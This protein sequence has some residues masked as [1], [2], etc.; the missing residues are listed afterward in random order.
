MARPSGRSNP[1]EVENET[2]CASERSSEIETA[3]RPSPQ[4]RNTDA[5]SFLLINISILRDIRVMSSTHINCSGKLSQDNN[6]SSKK[7]ICLPPE[8]QML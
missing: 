4:K 8:S 3:A 2:L 6:L 1:C 5:E 7:R